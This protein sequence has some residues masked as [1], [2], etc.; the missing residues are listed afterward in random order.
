[1]TE[2]IIAAVI[3]VCFAAASVKK[4]KDLKNGRG[5]GCGCSGCKKNGRCGK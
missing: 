4:I 5:C 2:I 1:M 3:A